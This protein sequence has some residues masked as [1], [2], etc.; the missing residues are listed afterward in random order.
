VSVIRTAA[1]MAVRCSTTRAR[2]P[3]RHAWT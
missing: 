1:M 3:A 2:R